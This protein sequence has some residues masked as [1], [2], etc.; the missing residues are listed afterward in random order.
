MEFTFS[1]LISDIFVARQAVPTLDNE[2]H[3]HY[4]SQ[5][6]ARIWNL[7]MRNFC[8]SEKMHMCSVDFVIA[9]IANLENLI[10]HSS[11]RYHIG[12]VSAIPNSPA[13]GP[14]DP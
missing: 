4:A 1:C 8:L 10:A 5:T 6:G 3:L 14:A 7:Y 9:V 11:L 12:T 13:S 2:H